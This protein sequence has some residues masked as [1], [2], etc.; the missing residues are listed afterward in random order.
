MQL[1][2]SDP[3]VQTLFFR[4]ENGD[5]DLQPDFQR[6]EVWSLAKRQ[7]LIDSILRNWHVPPI[8]VILEDQEQRASVLDGQ[9]RLAAI[10]DFLRG[11]IL[12]NG[13]I[14]P[15][16]E[17]LKRLHGLAFDELPP[18]VRRRVLQFPLRL[19]TI[20]DYDPAEPGEL[21]FRLNQ[22]ASLTAAE[23]RNAFFGAARKQVKDLVRS[24]EKLQLDENVFGFSNARMAYDDVISRVLFL[25]DAGTLREKVTSSALADKY[26]SSAAFHDRSVD[27]LDGA[28]SALGAVNAKTYGRL[29]LNKATA[30]SWLTFLA[31]LIHYAPGLSDPNLIANFI[32]A[33]E[34]QREVS[35]KG[36]GN[37]MHGGRFDLMGRKFVENALYEYESRST[38]RVAD[39]SSVVIRDLAIWAFFL[40]F[41]VN[42]KLD[43]PL[44]S[45]SKIKLKAMVK[46][47]WRLEQ[48]ASIEWLA[49]ELKWG[50][51]L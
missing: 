51:L 45:E 15:I 46:D 21:F 44:M 42:E 3:D 16:N 9:Q 40:S 4:I 8:H 30:Q 39:V 34:E 31:V 49:D 20:K 7:K 24:T 27:L 50:D 5:I 13:L 2:P 18:E 32:F 43:V 12:V 48:Y 23:Q 14:E 26:R 47:Q 38:A 28:L 17:Q 37:K 10:R 41:V 6:G 19:F 36:K 29:R 22:P 1:I 25:L 11:D 35:V 33:F